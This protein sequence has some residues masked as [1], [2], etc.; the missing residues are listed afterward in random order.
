MLQKEIEKVTPEE[1][2]RRWDEMVK[3]SQ[4]TVEI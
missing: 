3:D 4:A 1:M 2:Q